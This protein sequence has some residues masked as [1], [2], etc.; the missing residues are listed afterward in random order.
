[1]RQFGRAFVREYAFAYRWSL[2]HVAP[3]RWLAG[4]MFLPGT[5]AR[6]AAYALPEASLSREVVA[7]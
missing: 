2:R 1:M 5:P 4:A 3:W 6:A 7:I